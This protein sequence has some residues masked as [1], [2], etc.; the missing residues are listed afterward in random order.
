MSCATVSACGRAFGM[1]RSTG[2]ASVACIIAPPT[3]SC[4]PHH[5][6]EFDGRLVH[7]Q[8]V[9][10]AAHHPVAVPTYPLAILE[11]VGRRA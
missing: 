5:R 11:M 2:V 4:P 8:Q 10:A 3:R 7:Q 1:C 9:P 6:H